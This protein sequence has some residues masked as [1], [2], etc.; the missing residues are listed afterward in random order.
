MI[1]RSRRIETSVGILILAVIVVVASGVL[2]K[3]SRFDEKLFTVSLPLIDSHVVPAEN[4]N[5][6]SPF[7]PLVPAD[8]SPLTPPETFGPDNLSDKID[9][10][11]E[12]Y[13]SAGFKELRSQRFKQTNQQG[14]WLELFIFDMDSTQDA[15]SVFSTQR[16]ADG[17][18]INLTRFAYQTENALFFVHGNE[19]IE[20]IGNNPNLTDAM[21]AIGKNYVQQKPIETEKLSDQDLFPTENLDPGSISLLSSDVFGFSRLNDVYIAKYIINGQEI[22][23]FL[24]RRESAKD[25]QEL[26]EAYHQFLLENGGMD[27]EVGDGIAEAKLV[28]LFDLFELIFFHGRFFA[29]VHEAENRDSARK[30]GLLL[31]KELQKADQ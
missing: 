26:A 7:E 20:I 15:F 5:L 14:S 10:K 21:L 17:N 27:I 16:R 24:S 2:F 18:P 3:Q 11:A 8:M 13:L 12:L 29:G 6:T 28:E 31:L 30:L 4:A 23:A 19:Y 25:A 22:R 1:S 9:G